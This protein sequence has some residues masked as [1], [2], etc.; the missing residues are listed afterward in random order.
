LRE[1]DSLVFGSLIGAWLSMSLIMPSLPSILPSGC[2]GGVVVALDR[3]TIGGN[4]DR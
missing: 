1:S 2:R 3:F 4:L